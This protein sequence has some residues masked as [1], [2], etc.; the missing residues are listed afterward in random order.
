MNTQ[1]VSRI[2]YCFSL[3]LLP[4]LAFAYVGPGSGL[5]AIAT[6][7]A[8]LG[9]ITYGIVGFVWYPVKRLLRGRRS[10]GAEEIDE[11]TT[12]DINSTEEQTG[13]ERHG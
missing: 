6:V 1:N 8:L 9:A 13:S 2:L 11:T 12:D 7:L 10:A 5:G 3:A 4:N